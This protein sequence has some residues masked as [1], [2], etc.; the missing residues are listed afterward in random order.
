MIHFNGF[1]AVDLVAVVVSTHVLL[2]FLYRSIRLT[3]RGIDLLFT[4]VMLLVLLEAVIM[5]ASDNVV[6]SDVAA[7]SV[8]DAAGRTL[9]LYRLMYA[10]GTVLLAAIAHFGLRY[11]GSRHLAGARAGWLYVGAAAVVPLCFTEAFLAPR[12]TPLQEA[13]GW[14]CAAPWQPVAGPASAV[15]VFGWAAVNI[16]VQW[17]LWRRP[18]PAGRGRLLDSSN[19]VWGGITVWGFAG[20]VSLI[21]G[22]IGYAGVDPGMFLVTAAMVLLGVGL[23]E[24]HI[25]SEAQRTH[26]TRRFESYV[27]PA[28]VKYVIDHPETEHIAGEAR[29]LTVVFT[30]LVGFTALTE[31]LREGAVSLLNEYLRLM[32][33]LIRGHN[34]YRNKFLGD[35]MMFF[36]GAP[37]RNPDHAIHAVATV[38]KMQ[39]TMVTFNELIATRREQFGGD[40]PV[41]SMRTGVSSGQMIV[42]DAGPQ[43]ASDYTVLGDTVNL[44]ARLESANK[45]LGTRILLSERTVELLPK[46]LFILR[47]VG[48]LQVAGMTR[49]VMTYEPLA[50]ADRA[51]AAQRRV[52]EL[53]RALVESFVRRDFAACLKVAGEADREFGP[54]KLTALYRGLCE[55]HSHTAPGGDFVGQIVLHEK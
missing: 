51:T 38:L 42:G 48:R 34:G 52:A 29:E 13:S 20:L 8:P 32:V 24:D 9:L 17:L 5:F 11:A 54:G 14:L 19:L 25:R 3:K 12:A 40:L 21:L 15:F 46:D 4:A 27:D 35:G 6:P 22:A 28:L 31:R 23:A 50:H 37:E 30:D 45:Q 10:V 7:S 26:V 53:H 1:S 18:R 2:V 55:T 39:E 44:G 47:P 33:P 49:A 36:Y 41:L 16:Y 43:E